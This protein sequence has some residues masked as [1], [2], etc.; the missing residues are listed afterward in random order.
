MLIAWKCDGQKSSACTFKD[1]M[2]SEDLTTDEQ[3]KENNLEELASELERGEEPNELINKARRL[4]IM[5]GYEI[6]SK[7]LIGD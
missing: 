2:L 7:I 6:V 4:G 5:R 3:S 1:S